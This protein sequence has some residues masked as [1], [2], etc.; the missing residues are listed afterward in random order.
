MTSTTSQRYFTAF[1]REIHRDPQTDLLEETAF[2]Y[3]EA[4]DF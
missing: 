4:Y 3:Q 1:T 2:F